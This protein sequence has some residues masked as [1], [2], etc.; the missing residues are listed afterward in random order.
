MEVLAEALAEPFYSDL[1]GK[2]QQHFTY[3]PV[4]QTDRANDFH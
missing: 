3:V 1:L 4:L 2:T